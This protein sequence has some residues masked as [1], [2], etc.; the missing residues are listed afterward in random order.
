[1]F[2]F[3]AATGPVRSS[4]RSYR[5]Q[6]DAYSTLNASKALIWVNVEGFCLKELYWPRWIEENFNVGLID[7]EDWS[8]GA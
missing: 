1:M 2:D 7:N 3:H 5:V 4:C 6:A 8:G